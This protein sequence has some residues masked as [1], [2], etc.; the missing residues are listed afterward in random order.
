MVSG[1]A[2]LGFV[3]I[4]SLILALLCHFCNERISASRLAIAVL[5]TSLGGS[6][7][8]RGTSRSVGEKCRG[9]SAGVKERTTG[10]VVSNRDSGDT[11]A[12][13]GITHLHFPQRIPAQGAL[14][15]GRRLSKLWPAL[16]M[17]SLESFREIA[18]GQVGPEFTVTSAKEPSL[19]GGV[20]VEGVEDIG[21]G[22]RGSPGVARPDWEEIS[23]KWF[24][25]CG[26]T[27]SGDN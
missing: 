16:R 10:L 5:Q 6:F 11:P 21:L 7:L 22:V 24:Q 26:S 3:P 18:S 1:V 12:G 19:A 4:A 2:A 25:P 14:S 23:R 15:G 20:G 17:G 27:Q 8:W 9:R 13:Q